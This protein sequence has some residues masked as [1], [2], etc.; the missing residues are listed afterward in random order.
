MVDEFEKVAR[1]VLVEDMSRNMFSVFV[2][3]LKEWVFP[4]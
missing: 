3:R 2:E 1:Q 4:F